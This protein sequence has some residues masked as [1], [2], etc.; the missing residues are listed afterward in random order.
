MRPRA[1]QVSL[2]AS[3]LLAPCPGGFTLAEILVALVLLAWGGLAVVAASAA[4][5]RAVS[6][7]EARERAATAARDRV[8]QLA[9]HD[10]PSLQGGSV[11]DSS[12]GIR[13]RWTGTPARNGVRLI[14]DTVEQ[15]D[16]AAGRPLVLHRVL[17]C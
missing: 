5:V 4:A 9:S 13:E 7:A 6:A 3:P 15:L 14:V 12:N 11:V 1:F 2:P 16:R 10:C 8:E 17:L